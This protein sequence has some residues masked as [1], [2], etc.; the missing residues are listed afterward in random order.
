MKSTE[1]LK[2]QTG[3]SNDG[4]EIK[5]K[6]II[7]YQDY[8]NKSE[9]YSYNSYR[10]GRAKRGRGI[11][12][13]NTRYKSYNYSGEDWIFEKEFRKEKA[14][15]KDE[16]IFEDSKYENNIDII[17][18]NEVTE[19]RLLND[20]NQIQ[21][22]D[23]VENDNGEENFIEEGPEK[24]EKSLEI[25]QK[26]EKIFEEKIK[27]ENKEQK[28]RYEKI[29]VEDI[30]ENAKILNNDK[31]SG[32]KIFNNNYEVDT[33]NKIEIESI[34]KT[35]LDIINC[36]I[37]SDK[38]ILNKENKRN[39]IAPTTFSEIVSSNVTNF[40]F[41]GNANNKQFSNTASLNSNNNINI[42]NAPINNNTNH[43]IQNQKS[44]Q[45]QYSTSPQQN[46]N[47][48]INKNESKF[49]PS[50]SNNN[51]NYNQ[52][53]N[54]NLNP[55]MNINTNQELYN[56]YQMQMSALFTQNLSGLS[57]QQLYPMPFIYYPPNAPGNTSDP[58][59]NYS[60]FMPYMG[61]PMGYYVHPQQFTQ[62]AQNNLK[63]VN[64]IQN[65]N[66]KMNNFVKNI[67]FYG[68]KNLKNFDF[69]K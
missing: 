41:I 63:D 56:N 66:R 27:S 33:D 4:E 42:Q 23:I 16:G 51:N 30:F 60:N 35:D 57:Q 62:Q 46:I 28:V 19:K 2:K 3:D 58:N 38:D 65:K 37:N 39:F 11:Y 69:N 32:N 29:E 21:D 9:Y 45:S 22:E 36:S 44:T 54:T 6:N 55:N 18:E 34:Q 26:E 12:K 50:N 17:N 10:G 49:N 48:N 20:N 43:N 61:Y 40:S 68:F 1:K 59:F 14:E 24:V 13:G 64:D 8:Y 47:T 15:I 5:N 52:P 67:K 53:Q 31:I 25:I 7:K